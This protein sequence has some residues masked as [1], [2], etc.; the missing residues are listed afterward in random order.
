MVRPPRQTPE[1][2]EATAAFKLGRRT[3][4]PLV[5]AA[6]LAAF[7]APA[8][9]A[10]EHDPGDGNDDDDDRRSAPSRFVYVGTYTAPHTAP[11][12]VTPSTAKGIYAFKMDGRTG[13][14]SLIP[15]FD[16]ENPSWVSV[17]ADASHLYATS[18]VSTWKG[19]K[20]TGGITT[21]ATDDATPRCR[22]ISPAPE[23]CLRRPLGGACPN[24]D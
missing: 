22:L 2:A 3:L 20:N 4:F 10:A 9:A 5:G 13:G 24:S 12:G 17:D 18:E 1:Q 6:A 14:L 8:A 16:I 11:G 19:V 21:F 15:V 23:C 7:I